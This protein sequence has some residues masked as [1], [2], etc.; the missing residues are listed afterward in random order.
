MTEKKFWD[1]EKEI[2]RVDKGG[3]S[4][5]IAR[6]VERNGEKFGEVRQWFTDKDGN[7]RP[8]KKGLVIPQESLSDVR[9]MLD[10]IMDELEVK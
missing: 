5:Y 8:T 4:F 9:A 7:E 1:N 10:M 3:N 6:I 2:E